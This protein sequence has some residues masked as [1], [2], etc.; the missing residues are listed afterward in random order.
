MDTLK[1]LIHEIH[2]RS[3][4]QVVSIYLVGSW[5]A[6]QVVDQITQSA[7]LPDWVPPATLILLV[8]GLPIVTATAFIQEGMHRA[9]EAEPRTPAEQPENMAS[10]T[11]SLD[12]PS[13]RPSFA[14]G[15]FTWR[16]AIAG[17]VLAFLLLCV[18]VGGYFAM[19]AAG[20]GPVASLAAQGVFDEGEPVILSEFANTSNDASLG[21]VVTEAL[22]VDLASSK[23]FAIVPPNRIREVLK[24]MQRDPSEALTAQVAEEVAVRDGIKAVIEGEV[25]SAGS[26]YILVA[27]LRSP[28]SGEALA[29]FRRTAKGPDDVIDAIDGLSQDIREKAGESLR[30][31]KAEAPLAA[32]TT[33]SLDALRSYS[34]AEALADQGAYQRAR[35]LLEQA[36]AADSGFAMAWRKLAVV[37]SNSGGDPDKSDAAATKA[38]EL[39]DR[40]TERER[41]QAIAFYN[42][43]VAGDL[44]AEIEAY[45]GILDKWPDDA[46]A[47]NNLAL[48]YGS[49]TRWDDALRLLRRAV[50]GPGETGVAWL[51]LT[52]DL[53][54]VSKLDSAGSVVDTME[55]RYPGS[56]Q[57]SLMAHWVVAATAGDFPEAHLQGERLAQ[58]PDVGP[59]LRSAGSNLMATAD[60]G[61][62]KLAETREHLQ[63]VATEARADGQLA[64]VLEAKASQAQVEIAVLADSSAAREAMRHILASGDLEKIPVGRRP[65]SRLVEALASLGMTDD[66]RRILAEWQRERGQ[67]QAAAVSEARRLIEAEAPSDP[68][69]AADALGRLRSEVGCPHCFT[70]T[71][72]SLE[73]RAGRLEQAAELYEQSMQVA[74]GN[75]PFGESVSGLPFADARVLGHERLGHIYEELGD[76]A[77]AA[78]HYRKFAK[79]WSGADEELQPRVRAA[80]QKA[81][82]LGGGG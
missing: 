55:A 25:G 32:V 54:A 12:L 31:I 49:R 66:A 28:D 46:T 36:V 47:L 48:A 61:M 21:G 79:A 45:E 70:W 41:G 34:E 5:G 22:R 77:K 24:R 7:G 27:T 26:G 17:G 51:N 39:R 58:L 18:L 42:D 38:Y 78:E 8:V 15:L 60:L 67:T 53:A 20:V 65:Y 10:G 37:I 43:Q 40:L 69:A 57:T 35:A 68:G 59:G 3:L 4:W 81:A 44:A 9:E 71:M 14:R 72:A 64:T 74:S 63:R 56:A 76:S 62:G 2:R 30:S 73:E 6:L 50:R 52:L 82:A 33:S 16:N 11:G 23:A 29:T 19:R 13:T 80:K 1:R 75:M